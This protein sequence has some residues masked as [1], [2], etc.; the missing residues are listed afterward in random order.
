[1]KESRTSPPEQYS[2]C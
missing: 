1:M 2:W